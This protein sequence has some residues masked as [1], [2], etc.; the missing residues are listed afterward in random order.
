MFSHLSIQE[1]L[2][3]LEVLGD[4]VP[5]E[6]VQAILA[7]ES[8]AV[9]PLR[10]VLQDDDYWEAEDNSQWMPLHAVKLLGTLADPRAI[11]QLVNSLI[12]ANEVDNDWIME[13]FP[14]VFGRIGP[15]AIAP[16]KDFILA[17]KG[18]NELWWSRSAAAD[19]LIAIVFNH[20]LEREQILSFF[21]EL[22]LG[23]DDTEFLSFAAGSLLDL[24]D[25]SS[26]PVLEKAF[27]RGIIDDS[28]IDRDDLE[29]ERDKPYYLKNND[30]LHFYDP[31]EVAKR[32]ARWEE[33]KAE[34]DRYA[35]EKH[36]RREKSI[37]IELKRLEIANTLKDRNVPTF[38]GKVGRNEPCPCG[39]GKKFKKCCSSLYKDLPAK[40]VLG[41]GFYYN[42]W[43]DLQKA[44]PYDTILVL[45]NLTFLA[46]NVEMDGDVARAME[47][48]RIMKPLAEQNELFG[49][50]LHNW[51][52]ICYD[53]PELGGEGLDIL[54]QQ[55]SFFKDNDQE[56]WVY[57]VM[58]V[59]DY[60][61]R[62]GR[63]DEGKNEYEQLIELIPDNSFIRIRFAR[64]L[65]RNNYLDEAVASYVHVLQ[66]GDKVE[67]NDLGI[68][69]LE[70]RE[71]TVNHNIEL[72]S[73]ILEVIEDILKQ[74]E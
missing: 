46:F 65:E 3:K 68:A 6:L 23:E 5:M 19:G 10:D 74:V 48:F 62:M 72:E 41:N 58:D 15:P 18:D 12:L 26:F 27:D 16:L 37:A 66:L 22:L 34:R 8:E 49:E 30:L 24:G 36:E 67:E 73:C 32:Q 17:N 28:I 42:I 43:D 70:L 29:Q 59:A 14:T 33:E 69:A 13:D 38:T 31:E 53:H 57:A 7:K 55:E 60:L 4:Q 21:H 63:L 56:T 47:L 50:F 20:P 45:E 1:L 54:R 52:L 40:Q 44:T 39:S 61:D 35:A 64:L 9:V 71:L 51:G 2:S 11:P 25:T